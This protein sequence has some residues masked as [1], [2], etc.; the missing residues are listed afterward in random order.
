[1]YCIMYPNLLPC[2][3]APCAQCTRPTAVFGVYIYTLLNPSTYMRETRSGRGRGHQQSA[4][5]FVA[6]DRARPGLQ[7][8]MRRPSS[9]MDAL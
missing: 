9:A 1:M 4:Q 3:I 8:P 6:P 5:D 7:R 2:I